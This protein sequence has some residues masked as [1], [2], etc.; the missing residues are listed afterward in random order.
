[1]LG[2]WEEVIMDWGFETEDIK[3]VGLSWREPYQEIRRIRHLE[4][5]KKDK[6]WGSGNQV[7]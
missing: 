4:W 5:N 1:M 3:S 7:R 2:R 6:V